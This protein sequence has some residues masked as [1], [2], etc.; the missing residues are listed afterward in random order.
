MVSTSVYVTICIFTPRVHP[1]LDHICSILGD[2]TNFQKPTHQCSLP[3]VVWELPVPHILGISHSC[4]WSC[5]DVREGMS[6]C[7]SSGLSLMTSEKVHV[8]CVS[9]PSN[10]LFGAWPVCLVLDSLLGVSAFSCWW[11][12]SLK[13]QD[14]NSLW[15]ICIA[16]IFFHSMACLFNGVTWREILNFNVIQCILFVL[17]G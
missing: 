7:G 8:S 13:V 5:F 6:C 12:R 11:I 4:H 9:C 15:D 1:E 2:S 14:M 10:H 16:N 17:D 3:S